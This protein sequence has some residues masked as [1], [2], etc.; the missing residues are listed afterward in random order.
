VAVSE[1]H[2]VK[3]VQGEL[4]PELRVELLTEIPTPKEKSS[5]H[6]ILFS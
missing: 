5:V 6:V 2:L 4:L 1:Q 3:L